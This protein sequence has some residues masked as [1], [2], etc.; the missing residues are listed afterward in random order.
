MTESSAGG[1]PGESSERSPR[2]RRRRRQPRRPYGLFGFLRHGP[3]AELLG[4]FRD[5]LRGEED[6]RHSRG[7]WHRGLP[8]GRRR[9]RRR[10][11]GLWGWLRHGPPA[12]LL[13]VVLHPIRRHPLALG[14]SVLALGWWFWPWLRPPVTLSSRPGAVTPDIIAAS[15]PDHR[16]VR[17]A[18]RIW[19]D[20]PNA[21]LAVIVGPGPANAQSVE[22]IRNAPLTEAQRKRLVYVQT[23]GDT[24]VEVSDL[25]GWM[26]TL[27]RPGQVLMVTSPTHLQRMLHIAR[28]MLGGRGWHVDGIGSLSSEYKP[29]SPLRLLRDHLRAQLWRATGWTGKYSFICPGREQGLL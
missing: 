8:V 13:I 24:I 15:A 27:K 16:R 21:L 6:F 19:L 4:A 9:H 22:L 12:E 20:R 11:S 26:R 14:L 2:R 28:V 1:G 7:P 5:L 10:S 17:S 29:E 3:P 23:C 18:L 25:A